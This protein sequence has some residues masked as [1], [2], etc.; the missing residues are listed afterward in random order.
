MMDL[1]VGTCRTGGNIPRDSRKVKSGH[2]QEMLE[3][4]LW[5]EQETLW[6]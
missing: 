1:S 4:E 6:V 5:R 2:V 3:V